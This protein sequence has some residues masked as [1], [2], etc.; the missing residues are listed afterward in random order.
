MDLVQYGQIREDWAALYNHALGPMNN[1]EG[2][3]VAS[4]P[5]QRRAGPTADRL[6]G[7]YTS[8]YWARRS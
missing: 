3:L 1:A 7:V 5:G 2:S 8:D 6:P 4:S